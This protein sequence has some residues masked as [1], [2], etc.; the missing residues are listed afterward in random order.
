MNSKTAVGAA[1]L[2]SWLF[3][4]RVKRFISIVAFI[5]GLATWVTP[6]SAQAIA[7]NDWVQCTG[8]SVKI[9]NT[10][11]YDTTDTNVFITRVNAPEQGQVIS[12]PISNGGFVWWQVDWSNGSIPTGWSAADFLQ[13]VS[14]PVPA[15]PSNLFASGGNN[16]INLSWNDNSNNETGFKIDR[17]VDDGFWSQYATVAA[18]TTS[19]LDTSVVPGRIYYYRIYAYSSSGNS[20]FSNDAS[21]TPTGGVAPS[22]TTQS[23]SL[24]Q[25]TSAQMNA[26]V[27]PNGYAT[28]AYFQYGPTTSYVGTTGA[29]NLGNGNTTVSIGSTYSGLPPN[30][31]IHYRVVATNSG[32]TTY[33]GNVTFTTLEVPGPPTPIAPGSNTS[34][35]PVLGTLTPTFEWNAV[36]GATGYGLYIRDMT[37][38][39]LIFDNDGGAKI[40]TSF[41]LPPG[42]LSNNGHEYRWAVKS[43]AGAY[44]SPQS[45]YRYFSAP[46]PAPS[47]P[48]VASVSPDSV[49]GSNSLRTFTVTGSNFVSGAQI[50]VAW[51]NG[52][53][54]WNNPSGTIF[55]SSS[56]L[57]IQLN[58]QTTPDTWR[59]RV[60][61]PDGQFSA[62]YA[63]FIVNSPTTLP[64][65]TNPSPGNTNAPGLTIADQTPTFSW[66]PVVGA[67]RYSLV[68]SKAPYGPANVVYQNSNISSSSFTIPSGGLQPSTLYRWQVGAI[69]SG[70]QEGPSSNLLY[71][72]TPATSQAP[73][74]PSNLV[75][76]LNSQG[77]GILAWTDRSNNENGF[78]IERKVGNGEWSQLATT[79][80]DI[81]AFNDFTLS[82][83]STYRYRVSA[84]NSFGSSAASPEVLLDFPSTGALSL[85]ITS[86]TSA[87]SWMAGETRQ[88]TWMPSG[89]TQ[90]I[91]FIGVYYSV[92]GGGTYSQI[93]PV[94]AGSANSMSWQ[95]PGSI[96]STTARIRVAAFSANGVQLAT[97]E[98]LNFSI[99]SSAAKPVARPDVNNAGPVQGA[100]VNFTASASSAPSAR[101]IS[102]YQW[103]LGD[104]TN[105]TGMN[106]SHSYVSVGTYSATLTVTDSAG[107]SQS[108]SLS[109]RV[110]GKSL[111]A[112][113]PSS[114]FADPVN[115]ATGNF[116]LESSDLEIPGMGFPLK[117]SRFYNS[118]DTVETGHPIGHGW[119]HSYNLSLSEDGAGIVTIR[120][121][122][123][124][125]ET[126]NPVAGGGYTSEAGVR[127]QL[128]KISSD[129]FVLTTKDQ[130]SHTFVGGRLESISDRNNNTQV[131]TY[132][133]GKLTRITDTSGRFFAFAYNA[134]GRLRELRDPID[135]TVQYEYNLAGDLV[136][137]INP[138]NGRTRYTYDAL[139]QI[140]TA[141]DPNNNVFVTNEYD[142]QQRVVKVQRDAFGNKTDFEYDFVSGLTTVTDPFNNKT[143]H[144]HDGKLRLIAMTNELDQTESYEYDDDNNR[145]AVISRN[146]HTT[147]YLY[148]QRGNVTAKIDPLNHRTLIQYNSRNDPVFRM[149]AV[150]FAKSLIGGASA[151]YGISF[152]Y[153][154]RGNLTRSVDA[155]G[156]ATEMTY[157]GAG[158][159]LSIKDRRNHTTFH[160]YD[161]SGN[162]VR[163]INAL[164]QE[165][166]A[167]FDAV[168][169]M[170]TAE[171]ARNHTTHFTYDASDNLLT[172]RNPLDETITH[173][174]DAN[175]NRTLTRDAKGGETGFEFDAKDRLIT[176]TDAENGITRHEY[177][178]YDRKIKTT[179]ARV[180]ATN[181]E[182]DAAGRLK[183]ILDPLGNRTAY[184]YD[185]NGNRITVTD[186]LGK[187]TRSTHDPLDRL[188]TVTD[189]L[190]NTTRFEYDSLGRRT[191]QRDAL[192]RETRSEYDELGKLIKVTDAAGGIV[193]YGYDEEGNR[194]SMTN[195]MGRITRNFYDELNRLIRREEPAGSTERHEYDE[196]GNR[197]KRIDAKNQTFTYQYD[198]ANRLT[199]I[200]YPTGLPV[201]F[202]HD[203]NGNRLT[204]QDSVGASTYVYDKLN[205]MTSY[206]NP[207]GHVVGYE[208]DANSN[209]KT[210]IYPGNKRVE[211]LYDKA[212]RMTSVKDWGNRTTSYQYDTLGRLTT[213]LNPN[214]TSATQTY[215]D[216]SRLA[217]LSNRGPGNAVI[218]DYA[219][220]LDPVGNHLQVQQQEP[221]EPM[222]N[223]GAFSYEYDEEDRIQNMEGITQ[224][225]DA[226]GNLTGSGPDVQLS[227]DFENRL[228]RYQSGGDD[229]RWRYDGTGKRLE[230]DSGDNDPQRFVLDVN[231]SLTQ[232]IGVSDELGDI[233]EFYIYGLGLVSKVDESGTAT[234]YHYDS[235]GSTI[236]MTNS[237]GQPVASFAYD[238]FGRLIG[239]LPTDAFDRFTF[240]GRHGV[241]NDSN[242]FHYVR[243]RHYSVKRGRFL[244]KDPFLGHDD[245]SQTLNRYVYALNNPVRMIDV[246]GFSAKEANNLALMATPTDT[247]AFHHFLLNPASDMQFRDAA[248]S[249]AA[250]LGGDMVVS[251]IERKGI[252]YLQ[253][254]AYRLG[255]ELVGKMTAY[256]G[257]IASVALSPAINLYD[258]IHN[259]ELSALEVASQLSYDVGVGALTTGISFV[260]PGTGLIV[261]AALDTWGYGGVKALGNVG[262]NLLYNAAPWLFR[263]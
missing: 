64:A 24:I 106:V 131:F 234:Y 190:G 206:Q 48:T 9:R 211:Y 87:S 90:N 127:D 6:Q 214:G 86:P 233:Y 21:A 32:G 109:I 133:G 158:K 17:K 116:I 205:R 247:S 98:T 141:T 2:M 225:N 179:D 239:R 263:P 217:T 188:V 59:V 177:D 184:G 152:E 75:A 260:A 248:Y 203:A 112:E 88:I 204:M 229:W 67:T 176:I 135:R 197:I 180:N 185:P 137:I 144:L 5:L 118:K 77:I 199:R 91:G 246:S 207:F 18:N 138:R 249:F 151:G 82:A 96:T 117:F 210:L 230:K 71:F 14:A 187:I 174:Y 182:Y 99:A 215:D 111:G 54:A 136:T 20:A 220:T 145:T 107:Q 167:T 171:N 66:N 228:V 33:G 53:Y 219:Y 194:I 161:A 89:S 235:R 57:T 183:A 7:V 256:A 47:A 52:G 45:S 102:S 255:P 8:T 166:T 216:A 10:P 231:T 61:N 172:L 226:N 83:G 201:I 250:N 13:V 164:S 12:G 139:H 44:E 155:K 181:F 69:N 23:A 72:Q 46:S 143:K 113:S 198:P 16:R 128:A 245:Q 122:D 73:A 169:R 124:R 253:K 93:L 147:R 168:G 212:N 27:N 241:M 31:T 11:V 140:R 74:A 42:Y 94:Q 192:L 115:L 85:L 84:F 29:V 119:T 56:T 154:T 218:S 34:P 134:E 38:D 238:P 209:R 257:P 153:D 227:Y 81:A 244:S 178:A 186:P 55:V 60:Q 129:N 92:N 200:N 224:T 189:P 159:L 149:D 95:I 146:G 110:S 243:A 221:I 58:T 3:T 222:P 40:G 175:G 65:P 15:S 28:S 191:V 262:G 195:P 126:H 165:S 237:S 80:T 202:T 79:G 196:V 4:S 39:T 100:T 22:V 160:E 1:I 35:G 70:G 63:T 51:G 236:S 208:Y 173:T 101:T 97:H 50:Q 76:L 19:A 103:N 62:V 78:R 254:N 105:K 223:L 120:F 163:T 68:I 36:N 213:T 251:M 26:S 43:F 142:P 37:T 41:A 125:R 261:G 30:T 242:G 259:P 157:N 170:L 132:E 49:P 130:I 114:Y 232:V 258:N 252:E 108:S 162:R 25:T 150:G 104:G 123:G 240:L 156:K 148:D 121:G 193:L